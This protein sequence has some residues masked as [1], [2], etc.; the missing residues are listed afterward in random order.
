MT[1]IFCDH[2]NQFIISTKGIQSD[3]IRPNQENNIFSKGFKFLIP[4]VNVEIS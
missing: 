1:M 4:S 2:K 3:K